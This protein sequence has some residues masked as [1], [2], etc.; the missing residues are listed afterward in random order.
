MQQAQAPSMKN[1]T[2]EQQVDFVEQENSGSI[3]GMYSAASTDGHS[4]L[5]NAVVINI[6]GLF[7]WHM[8]PVNHV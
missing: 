6:V 5:S 3:A 2:L 1:V 7:I 8:H 4:A